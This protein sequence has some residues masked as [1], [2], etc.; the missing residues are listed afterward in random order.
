[1]I[2]TF[3]S[4]EDV[5]DKYSGAD[6]KGWGANDAPCRSHCFIAMRFLDK[7]WPKWYVRGPPLHWV[8]QGCPRDV[9][10][11]RRPNS[12]VFMQFSAKHLQNNGVSTPTL[13][14]G[15]PPQDNPGSTTALGL[16]PQPLGYPPLIFHPNTAGEDY[17]SQQRFSWT[18]RR[19]SVSIAI[20]GP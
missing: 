10:S 7:I 13:G 16:V 1:M 2:Y 3:S 9:H 18:F 19:F 15:A 8:I 11:R 12:F 20:S 4:M 14:I 5:F 6:P 17:R